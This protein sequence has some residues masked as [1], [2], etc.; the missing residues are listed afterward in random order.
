MQSVAA[1]GGVGV[2]RQGSRPET[3]AVTK[4]ADRDL[5]LGQGR[6]VTFPGSIVIENQKI[7]LKTED[8]GPCTQCSKTFSIV[9]YVIKSTQ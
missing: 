7:T 6:K 2:A 1:L 9:G 8:S 5:Q 3:P 4:F